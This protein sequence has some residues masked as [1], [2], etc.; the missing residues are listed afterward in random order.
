MT[1]KNNCFFSL[2]RYSSRRRRLFARLV[3]RR[4]SSQKR[5]MVPISPS[6]SDYRNAGLSSFLSLT[7]VQ[8]VRPMMIAGAIIRR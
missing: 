4:F 1:R 2:L 6:N 3:K 8:W 5:S 7:T